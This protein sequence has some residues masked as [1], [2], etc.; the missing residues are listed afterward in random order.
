M[1]VTTRALVENISLRPSF[2]S[3]CRL[4]FL[5]SYSLRISPS[6]ESRSSGGGGYPVPSAVPCQP[7]CD[8]RAWPELSPVIQL[9]E[10]S[11]GLGSNRVLNARQR[12][13]GASQSTGQLCVGL[14]FS[15]Y[16]CTTVRYFLHHIRCWV[17]SRAV[18]WWS[19][20]P[21]LFVYCVAF[22]RAA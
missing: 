7:T 10:R 21:G 15:S 16:F 5:E 12:L 20:L 17:L 6:F 1:S 11:G 4:V 18:R 2:P 8:L 22:G 19:I 9:L 14:C 3:M 13:S